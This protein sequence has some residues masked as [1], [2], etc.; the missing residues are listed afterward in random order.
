ME[1]FKRVLQY[2]KIQYR[3]VLLSVIFAILA[4]MLLSFSL[5]AMLPLMKVMIGEEG[6]HGWVNRT[7]IKHRSGIT[8]TAAPLAEYINKAAEDNLTTGVKLR[9]DGIKDDSPAGATNLVPQD[10]V[11][12]IQFPGQEKTQDI[13]L[14]ILL[15]QFASTPA[16]QTVT[17]TIEHETSE[18]EMIDIVLQDPL[19][20]RVYGGSANRLLATCHAVIAPGSNAIPSF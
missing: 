12:A 6:L 1:Y 13:D 7:I 18:V 9:I 17:L 10:E 2:V 11:V 20:Y 19:I 4:A 3:A 15:E 16:G 5:A 14:D 8:F